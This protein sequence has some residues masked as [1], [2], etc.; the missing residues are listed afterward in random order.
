MMNPYLDNVLESEV[1]VALKQEVEKIKIEFPNGGIDFRS[2]CVL[3]I[4]FHCYIICNLIG[5]L[6]TS[7]GAPKTKIFY[8]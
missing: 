6:R 1:V 7:S 8:N 3:I 4:S 2:F 5:T